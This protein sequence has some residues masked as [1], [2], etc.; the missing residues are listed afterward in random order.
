MWNQVKIGQPVSEKKTFKDYTILYM[1]IAQG[2]G[3]IPPGNKILIVTKNWFFFQEFP[4]N[5]CMGKQI[6]LP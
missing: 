1:S 3:Q 5:K 4:Q 6:W 2:Q